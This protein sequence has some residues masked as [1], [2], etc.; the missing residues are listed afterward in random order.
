MR[1]LVWLGLLL[2]IAAPAAAQ[3]PA[4]VS[5]RITN[6]AGNPEAAVVV[7]I[8]SLDVNASSR[9]DGTY[10]LVVPGACIRPGMSVTIT[11]SRTALGPVSRTVV[12]SPDSVVTVD[13]TMVVQVLKLEDII[14]TGTP[15][16]IVLSRPPC[17]PLK[18]TCRR[19][20]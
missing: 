15:G 12:P 2:L 7:R 1:N 9:A 13:L 4:I 20:A 11:A 8:E 18:R 6:S 14:V 17:V 19:P 16:P 5:G 10:E 3:G